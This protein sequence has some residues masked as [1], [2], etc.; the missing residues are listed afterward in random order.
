MSDA[1]KKPAEPDAE[2]LEF[3]GG[4][5]EVGEGDADFADFL[6]NTDIDRIAGPEK[7]APPRQ[8]KSRE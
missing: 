8:E 3:L 6:A 4:F 2:L 1:A 7:S 5:D